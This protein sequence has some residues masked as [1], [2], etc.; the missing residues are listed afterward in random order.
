MKIDRKIVQAS[1]I[2]I[3]IILILSTYY[4]YPKITA[5]KKDINIQKEESKIADSNT[6]YFEN[7]EYSG[8][9]NIDNPFFVNSKKATILQEDPNIVYMTG[10]KATLEMKDGRT[11]VI[12]SDKGIYNKKTY[13]CYFEKN[14][15][16]TDGETILNSENIDLIS[17]ENT[18]AIYNNVVLISDK[19]SLIADKIDYDF[20]TKYYK[21]SMFSNDKVNI[22][23]S[24]WVI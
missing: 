11:V 14:V 23:L 13:D 12:T 5:A 9:Y 17:S 2:L 22:K 20:S 4:L 21:V 8:L 10:M 7:L 3:G 24:R 18:A 16:A 15:K 6:N 1:L 19:G